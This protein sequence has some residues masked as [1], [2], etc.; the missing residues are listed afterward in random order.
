[1]NIQVNSEEFR[2]GFDLALRKLATGVA[3]EAQVPQVNMQPAP[4]QQPQA[5]PATAGVQ[6][7]QGAQ[8]QA[9][10]LPA[11][12]S[13]PTSAPATGVVEPNPTGPAPVAPAAPKPFFSGWGNP[14][15]KMKEIGSTIDGVYQGAQKVPQLAT[16][17]EGTMTDVGGAA[18]AHQQA[19]TDASGVMKDI[20]PA[21][22]AVGRVGETANNAMDEWG[23]Y[24]SDLKGFATGDTVTSPAGS[25]TD[26]LKLNPG[27]SI[28]TGITSLLGAGGLFMLMKKL[29]SGGGGGGGGQGG[30]N[31]NYYSGPQSFSREAMASYNGIDVNDADLQKVLQNPAAR[32]Y[33]ASLIDNG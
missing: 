15:D 18:N 6:N 20:A 2:R 30:R 9:S 23:G 4:Q 33:I 32:G 17:M 24:L 16:K 13:T 11:P 3:P 10:N 22:K 14:I 25:I 8:A 31:P 19:A 5:A 28:L 29:L 7:A 27:K 12:G 21:A 1:M 26:F